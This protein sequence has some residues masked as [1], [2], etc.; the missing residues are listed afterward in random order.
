MSDFT[1]GQRVHFTHPMHRAFRDRGTPDVMKAWIPDES[2]PEREG[3]IVGRRKLA[4]GKRYWEGEEVGYIFIAA[5]HVTAYLIAYTMHNKPI[6]VLP[7][8]ITAANA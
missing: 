6:P 2:A 3:I 7:E 5:E 8:H 1:L 4:N